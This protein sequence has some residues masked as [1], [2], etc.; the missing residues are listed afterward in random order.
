MNDDDL[1]GGF[2]FGRVEVCP[3]LGAGPLGCVDCARTLLMVQAL[4]GPGVSAAPGA[5]TQCGTLTADVAALVGV[6]ALAGLATAADRA[7]PGTRPAPAVRH[8]RGGPVSAAGL[9]GSGGR[10]R[11]A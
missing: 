7:V 2:G 4:A 3:E 1:G 6:P 10:H 8:R 5:C 9:P 11:R